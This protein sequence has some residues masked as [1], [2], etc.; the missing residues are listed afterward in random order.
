MLGGR[1]GAGQE[2]KGGERGGEEG[3]GGWKGE[4][5][6]A[7]GRLVG[8]KKGQQGKDLNNPD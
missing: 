2:G 4:R 1:Q 7:R 8:A 6:G 5:K 3:K